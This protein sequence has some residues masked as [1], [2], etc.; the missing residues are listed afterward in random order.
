M[1]VFP[2]T[3]SVLRRCRLSMSADP[4]SPAD[5]ETAPPVSLDRIRAGVW[6]D[7]RR[8]TC[9]PRTRRCIF[10]SRC[11]VG[12]STGTSRRFWRLGPS[13]TWTPP[14][15]SPSASP[16]LFHAVDLLGLGRQAGSAVGRARRALAAPR[17]RARQSRMRVASSAPKRPRCVNVGA[18]SST[19]HRQIRCGRQSDRGH[20]LTR[21]R[22]SIPR[23]SGCSANR[24]RQAFDV[25]VQMARYRAVRIFHRIPIRD[26][27][28]DFPVRFVIERPGATTAAFALLD[29]CNPAALPAS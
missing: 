19:L 2:V 3:R 26:D 21:R 16:A 18:P 12:G 9:R 8:S 24:H 17:Q 14:P 13:L 27:R 28:L 23:A 5:G 29:L 7:H 15:A 25:W 22:R 10:T 1:N 11:K 20:G 4:A 6:H